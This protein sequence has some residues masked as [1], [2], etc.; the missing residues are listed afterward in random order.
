MVILSAGMLGSHGIQLF[1]QQ[2]AHSAPL[3]ARGLGY[4]QSSSSAQGDP[5]HAAGW[6]TPLP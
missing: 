3:C 6:G 2:K 1:H 4:L 5:R